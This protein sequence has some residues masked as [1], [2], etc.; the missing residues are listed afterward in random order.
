MS[1]TAASHQV[2]IEQF[3]LHFRGALTSLCTL[4]H[5]LQVCRQLYEVMTKLAEQ[6]S[7][8]VFTIQGAPRSVQDL[9]TCRMSSSLNHHVTS[10]FPSPHPATRDRCDLPGRRHRQRMRVHLRVRT[11]AP[12]TCSAPSRLVHHAPNLPH[13]YY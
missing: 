13:R 12:T 11:P 4:K 5:C 3:R 9:P 7:D 6:H 10:T 2:V 1:Y 8:K